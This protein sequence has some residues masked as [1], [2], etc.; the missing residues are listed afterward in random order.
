MSRLPAL[1]LALLP[2][3]TCS[4]T[5][6]ADDVHV[7]VAANFTAPMKDIA[8]RFTRDTGHTV[9]ASYGATGKFYAQI[10]NGAPFEVLLAADDET[11]ARLERDG[12]AAAGSRFTY[13][14]GR[15]VLWS[16][17]AA[18]V[19]NQGAV[20]KS[21]SLSFVAIANPKVAPYGAAAVE[22]LGKLNL[23][24]AVEP[25]FVRGEN[26]AQTHQFVLSGNAPLGFVAMS[27][28]YENGKLRSGS[29]WV[30]PDNLHATIRQDAVLL[31]KGKGK[32][33]AE[34]FVNYLKS[35]QM[36]ALIRGYG[37]GDGGKP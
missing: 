31:A 10:R 20:L 14:I 4:L 27:Q 26:I 32:P 9:L 8:A 33:A 23:L 15:L 28:V 5:A 16:P 30:V 35:D 2:A 3:F 6:R 7:A 25:R 24:A 18:L 22:A 29:A 1:L 13:A 21:P 17:N 36:R 37:Y 34:A 11:P 12:A 19:D